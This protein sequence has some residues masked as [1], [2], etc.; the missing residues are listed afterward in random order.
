MAEWWVLA[1]LGRREDILLS[2]FATFDADKD[3]LIS[4]QDLALVTNQ[5]GLH[6]DLIDINH[7]IQAH[8]SN[9]DGKLDFQE[10]TY[11]TADDACYTVTQTKY[12][13]AS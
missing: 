8:D 10:V 3:G 12:L 9:R 6:C 5:K 2:S 7:M 1:I 11:V 4:E 13:P